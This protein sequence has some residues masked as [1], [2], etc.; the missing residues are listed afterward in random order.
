MDHTT[1]GINLMVNL[2]K[3]TGET[4]SYEYESCSCVPGPEWYVFPH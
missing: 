2:E 3:S 4:G 1:C